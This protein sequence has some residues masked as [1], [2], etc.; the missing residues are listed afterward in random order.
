MTG[1]PGM[2]Q[3]MGLQRVRH[4]WA[5]ELNWPEQLLM[6]LFLFHR[7][8]NFGRGRISNWP[9][10]TW[11]VCGRTGNLTIGTQISVCV[12]VCVCYSLS[13]GRLFASPWTVAR[14]G[15]LS[16]EFSRQ[17]HWSGLLF[18]SPGDLPW[19][20]DPALQADYLPSE[21]PGNQVCTPSHKTI[22]PLNKW[23]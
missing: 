20:R 23:D 19:P 3:S 16:M 17:E 5:T 4:D 10:V 2:L 1:W 21:L 15:P 9:S 11:L 8:E 18:P 7:W 14:Q 12:C 13:R 22:Q 6:L